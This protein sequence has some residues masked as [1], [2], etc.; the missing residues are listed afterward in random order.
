MLLVQDFLEQTAARTPDHIGLVCGAERLTFADLDARSNRIANLLLARGVLRGDRVVLWCPNSVELVVAIF[1]AL[2]AGAVFVVQNEASKPDQVAYVVGNCR[3][4]ALVTTARQA[5]PASA[6]LDAGGTLD[7]VLQVDGE[8]ADARFV[9]FGPASLAG[10]ASRPR[11]ESIDRDLACLVYTSGSTG[12]PKGVMS[13][14]HQVVFASGSILQYLGI[15]PADVV[16]CALPLAF[17]YGLYQLL[18]TFRVGGTL[19]LERS[20]TYPAE[21]L[22]RVAEERI[23]VLPCVPTM[24]ALLLDLDL[25]QFDVSSVRILTNTAAALPPSHV[26]RLCAAFPRAR[27]FKM[28]GLTETKRTLYLPPEHLASHPASVGFPIPGTEVWIESETGA[29]LGPGMVGELVVRGGHVMSGYWEAPEETAARFPPGPHP[30]ERLCRTGDLFLRDEAGFHYFVGRADDM[31]KCRGEKVAPKEIE[32]VL[33]EM[34]GVVEAVVVGVPDAVLGHAIVAVVVRRDPALTERDVLRHCRARLEDFKV[35][36]R[37]EFHD[38]LPKTNTGKV[39]RS[40]IEL[41]NG[42]AEAQ[43]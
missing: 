40:A 4:R 10:D 38:R 31:L 29:R 21:C 7:T 28:Y 9:A 33:H 23:T 27:L 20:F 34:P 2:K 19:V 35:P 42:P 11:C 1:G 36:R 32:T 13:A 5:G 17:D 24:F 14:H 12:R 26:E 41:R 3:A 18:M 16:L 8:P 39:Q 37:V 15:G 22:L 43:A 30:G 6:W 25:R